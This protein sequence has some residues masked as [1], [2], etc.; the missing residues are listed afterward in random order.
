[1][2]LAMSV[3]NASIMLSSFSFALTELYHLKT[4]LTVCGAKWVLFGAERD[5]WQQNR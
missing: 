4:A 3:S 2:K 5:F 1:M